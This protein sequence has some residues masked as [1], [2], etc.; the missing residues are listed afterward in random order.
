MLIGGWKEKYTCPT[1]GGAAQAAN[2]FQPGQ[3]ARSFPCVCV[4]ARSRVPCSSLCFLPAWMEC[5]TG[6]E[7]CPIRARMSLVQGAALPLRLLFV[8]EVRARW[9]L[10]GAPPCSTFTKLHRTEDNDSEIVHFWFP[11]LIKR[12]TV[13]AELV[14]KCCLRVLAN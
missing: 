10:V 3:P 9:A 4:F 8:L 12:C 6:R 1:E 13:N 2:P 7:F 11:P 14:L 5:H